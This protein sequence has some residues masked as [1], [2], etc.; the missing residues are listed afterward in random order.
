MRSRRWRVIDLAAA[1]LALGGICGTRVFGS[2]TTEGFDDPAGQSS[3]GAAH[4]EV[5]L[6]RTGND[7]VVMYTSPSATVDDPAFWQAVT[8]TLQALPH[9]VVTRTVT[10]W[11]TGSPALDSHDHHATY[12]APTLAGDDKAQRGEG[13]DEIEDEPAAPGLQTQV[14]GATTVDRDIRER[15]AADIALRRDD[16]RTG[17]ARAPGRRLRHFGRGEHQADRSGDAHRRPGGRDD[18]PRT[19]GTGHDA[20]ARRRALVGTGAPAALLRPPRPPGG[21]RRP[22]WRRR[23][24]PHA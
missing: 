6:G 8:E 11:S 24:T 4:A 15:V 2:L 13:L 16:L 7:A 10:D 22:S 18:R 12:A 5:T 1:F 14:G 17:A 9:D 23:P 20:P 21:R 3:R 19:A